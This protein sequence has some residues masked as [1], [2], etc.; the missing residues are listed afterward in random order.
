M[1]TSPHPGKHTEHPDST[2]GAASPP[3]AAARSSAARGRAARHR[4]GDLSVLWW[5]A[6]CDRRERQRDARL[7]SCPASRGP[8]HPPEIRLSDLRDGSASACAGPADRRR[9]G[10]AGAFGA[11]TALQILRPH[12][13]LQAVA[14]IRPARCRPR[15]LDARMA[16]LPVKTRE[17]LAQLREEDIDTPNAGLKLVVA[18][19]TVGNAVKWLIVGILGLFAGVVMFGESIARIVA[20]LRPP[21]E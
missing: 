20:W 2:I 1:P 21:P 14:D 5:R 9:I 4:R 13:A 10:D 19:M 6:P 15:V 17:F 7:G 8:H 16:E 12:A 11:G 3:Q 18:T